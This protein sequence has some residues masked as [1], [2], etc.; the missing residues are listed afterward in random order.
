MKF[1]DF[2]TKTHKKRLGMTPEELLELTIPKR[3]QKPLK[4]LGTHKK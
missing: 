4:F 2:F 3:F 1:I